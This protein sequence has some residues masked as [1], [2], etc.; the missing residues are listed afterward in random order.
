ME[1]T[2]SPRREVSLRD[3]G[4]ATSGL[5]FGPALELALEE[6][7]AVIRELKDAYPQHGELL[8]PKPTKWDV[9]ARRLESDEVFVEYLVT[10]STT[11]AFVVTSDTLEA[12]DLGIDRHRLDVAVEF[13]RSALGRPASAGSRRTWRSPMRQLHARLVEPLERTGLLRGKTALRIA[14]HGM[15]HYLPF[16]ALLR[17]DMADEFLAE[18]YE[19]TYVPSASVWLQLDATSEFDR[20]DPHGTGPTRVLALAPEPSLLPGSLEEASAIAGRFPASATSPAVAFSTRK[21]RSSPTSS[22]AK[23]RIPT[24]VLKSTRSLAS[25]F[26]PSRLF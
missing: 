14:P 25:T 5:T 11:V 17:G 8:A 21:T 16:Q 6:H 13:A 4:I 10:D 3:V 26:R 15:L 20:P 2:I 19:I 22:S 9:V 23:M 24:A 18:R 7:S 1:A 12:I